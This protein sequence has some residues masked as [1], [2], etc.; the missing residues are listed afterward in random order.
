MQGY[1]VKPIGA[2]LLAG[3]LAEIFPG[4]ADTGQSR[5]ERPRK[6]DDDIFNAGEFTERYAGDDGVEQEIISLF[7]EQSQVLF[8]EGREA[9]AA[10]SI[11][12]FCARVHRLKGAAG[13][14][15]CKRL[16][17]AANAINEVCSPE[18]GEPLTGSSMES[19]ANGFERELKLALEA[20]AAYA[21]SRASDKR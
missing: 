1:I 12:T 13:T 17:A 15:G 18:T 2:A 4:R 11:D 19:L 21:A 10:G 7:L 16:V 6:P 3:A 9:L 20:V 14:M 5:A 8:D